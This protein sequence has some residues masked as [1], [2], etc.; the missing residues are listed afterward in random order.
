MCP[1]IVVAVIK[2]VS[3]L[4]IVFTV[5]K[6]LN[7]CGD[8]LFVVVSGFRHLVKSFGFSLHQFQCWYAGIGACGCLTLG[9][10]ACHSFNGGL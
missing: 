4:D 3:M 5:V 2:E 10:V 8:M 1:S 6:L 9:G 7:C